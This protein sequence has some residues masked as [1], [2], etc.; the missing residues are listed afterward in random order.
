[1]GPPL[2]GFYGQRAGSRSDYAYSPALA[3]AGVVWNAANL[4]AFLADPQGFLPGNRML[5]PGI[6]NRGLRSDL[7]FFLRLATSHG[8][9]GKGD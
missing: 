4:N 9:E 5:S 6:E 1:V 2:P 3:G 8:V 7:I